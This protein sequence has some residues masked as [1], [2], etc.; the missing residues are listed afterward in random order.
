MESAYASTLLTSLE[1]RAAANVLQHRVQTN[2]AIIDDLAEWFK[3]LQ[4]I[5]Q[6]YCKSLANL[7]ARLPLTEVANM[8][9]EQD[10]QF[11]RR[12]NYA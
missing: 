1:P 8:G 2:R 7:T 12:L 5:E 6:A 3:E 4:A 9:Y 10:Y 11:I